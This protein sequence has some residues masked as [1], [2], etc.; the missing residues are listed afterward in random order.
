MDVV[1]QIQ[2]Q[3]KDQDICCL[4]LLAP[5]SIFC[6]VHALN[7]KLDVCLSCSMNLWRVASAGEDQSIFPY[8]ACLYHCLLTL[9]LVLMGR[10]PNFEYCPGKFMLAT[11]RTLKVAM[12]SICMRGCSE[13]QTKIDIS[14]SK[15]R[16]TD[17]VFGI[18][19][20]N[21][22]CLSP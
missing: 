2:L 16:C 15:E 6:S 11:Y 19:I 1:R 3:F 10:P 22:L 8:L 12:V 21:C 14:S 4:L 7:H 5:V 20:P 9:L 13:M 18:C 17:R